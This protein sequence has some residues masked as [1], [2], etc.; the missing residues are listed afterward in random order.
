VHVHLLSN[1]SARQNAIAAAAVTDHPKLSV[2][3]SCGSMQRSVSQMKGFIDSFAWLRN[4][5][6]LLHE[7]VLGSGSSTNEVLPVNLLRDFDSAIHLRSGA[8]FADFLSRLPSISV[9][10]IAHP[11]A[12]RLVRPE[13]ADVYSNLANGITRLSAGLHG[14]A[15]L[16]QA[17]A[18]TVPSLWLLHYSQVAFGRLDVQSCTVAASTRATEAAGTATGELIRHCCSCCC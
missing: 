12:D 4:L 15:A 2:I 18:G 17:P 10:G 9:A 8:G 7:P 1:S 16:S 14:Q 3:L 6:A 5:D 11:A 13:L